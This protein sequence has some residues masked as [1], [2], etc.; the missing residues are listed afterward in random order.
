[1]QQ[2]GEDRVDYWKRMG[3]KV[4]WG[5]LLRHESRSNCIYGRSW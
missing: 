4:L 3:R 5:T 2:E 1:M